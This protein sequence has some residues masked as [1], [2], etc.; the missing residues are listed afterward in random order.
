M[1]KIVFVAFSA[2]LAL[3]TACS[4]ESHHTD[5]SALP[6]GPRNEVATNFDAKVVGVK[7]ESNTFGDDD[8]EIT[9]DDGSRVEYEGDQWIEVEA[10]AGKAV[11]DSYVPTAIL[12]YVMANH[13]G[14]LITKIERDSKGYELKLANGLKLK[15]DT[16]CAFVEYD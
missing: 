4:S 8:Y 13:P 15:F 5:A 16:N 9:L 1:S 7:V 10:A 2:C 6:E 14:Q 3:A 12:Q 11:P